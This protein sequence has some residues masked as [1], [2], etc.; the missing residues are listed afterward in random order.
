MG[1]PGL[2]GALAPRPKRQ[3]GQGRA[4]GRPGG[5]QGHGS[6]AGAPSQ[7][8]PEARTEKWLVVSE[9]EDESVALCTARQ[10]FRGGPEAASQRSLSR[11]HCMVTQACTRQ[12]RGRWG[13]RD[14]EGGCTTVAGPSRHE[15]A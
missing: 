2:A 9:P 3:A 7:L 11:G 5:A 12:R 6:A 4:G 14:G 1:R 15:G 10:R 13:R 8:P